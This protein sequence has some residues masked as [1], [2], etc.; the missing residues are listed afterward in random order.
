MRLSD[1]EWKIADCLWRRGPMT[2]TE[3][4]K[5][6]NPSCG[7]SKNVIITMLKRMM[8]KGAVEF[9]QEERAKRFYPTIDRTEAELE[10]TTTFLDKVYDGNVGLMIS[11]LIGSEK[12]SDEQ[13]AELRRIVEER[14][15]E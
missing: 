6:L 7:W 13:L 2:I 9:V 8:E 3:L 12:L 15:G 4:T 1:A 10:E 5:E 14:E 11:K